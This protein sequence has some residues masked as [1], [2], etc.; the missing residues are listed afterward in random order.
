LRQEYGSTNPIVSAELDRIFTNIVAGN[1]TVAGLQLTGVESRIPVIYGLSFT[2][3]QLQF[4]I[5]GYLST[6]GIQIQTSSNLVS[7]SWQTISTLTAGTNQAIFTTVVS[8]EPSP[9]F[10][11]IGNN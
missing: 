11:R 10:F 3:G 1:L 9:T 5:G 7:A 2:N 8:P 6:N 4:S